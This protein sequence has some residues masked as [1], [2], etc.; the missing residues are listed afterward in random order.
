MGVNIVSITFD[1]SVQ[2]VQRVSIGKD[3]YYNSVYLNP[4]KQQY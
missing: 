2:V 1:T 3:L 4:Q